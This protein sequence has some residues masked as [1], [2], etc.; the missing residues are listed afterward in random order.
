MFLENLNIL[1]KVN[2]KGLIVD[3]KFVFIDILTNLFLEL[4]PKVLV[5]E[6]TNILK[7]FHIINP[8]MSSRYFFIVSL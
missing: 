7:I 8:L 1:S 3:T 5:L 2:K 4:V 6:R